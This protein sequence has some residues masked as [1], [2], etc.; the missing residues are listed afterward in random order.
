MLFGKCPELMLSIGH[1][2][3][4]L[5]S[6]TREGISVMGDGRGVQWGVGGDGRHNVEWP[7]N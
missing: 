3:G 1:S 4:H 6:Q 5:F 2:V 7:N